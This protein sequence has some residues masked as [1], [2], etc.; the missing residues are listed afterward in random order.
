MK[1]VLKVLGFYVL[2]FV[3]CFVVAAEASSTTVCVIMVGI[4]MFMF[5]CTYLYLLKPLMGLHDA[6]K[7]IDFDKDIIDFSKLDTLNEEG[8][9]EVK[10]IIVKFKYL[11]DIIAER[12]NKVNSETYK[13]E[14]DELTGCYNRAHL[15]RVKDMYELQDSVYIIFIDVN[16]L[17]RMNDTFGHEA[18][19]TLIRSAARKLNTWSTYGDVYRMGGDEFMVVIT[20]KTKEYCDE[21]LHNWYPTVGQ[22]NRDSDGFK[23]VLSYGVAFGNKGC[24]FDVLEK[25]ADDRMYDFK[26]AIKKKFGEPMR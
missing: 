22:L 2:L 6:L 1:L 9:A 8:F 23:C 14:H 11:L 17:K 25:E 24:K 18:G 7:Y 21:A 20:N 13:S 4:F 5:L 3:I 12:I 19:D 26:V 10:F 15:E 16:N